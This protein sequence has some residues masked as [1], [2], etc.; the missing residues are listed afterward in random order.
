MPFLNAHGIA[1]YYELRG[2][3]API[4]FIHGALVDHRAWDPQASELEHSHRV[5]RYDLRGHGRTGPSTNALYT[6][7]LFAEDLYVLIDALGLDHP[8]LCGLSL[9]GMIAQTYALR[10]PISGLVLAD[11]LASVRLSRCVTI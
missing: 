9:G 5:L 2:E 11:T 3:G 4:V 1:Q 6:V 7:D 8:L 10:Y